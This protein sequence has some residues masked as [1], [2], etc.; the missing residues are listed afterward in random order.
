MRFNSFKIRLNNTLI[1]LFDIIFSLLGLIIFSP[2]FTIVSFSIVINSKGGIFYKQTRIGLNNQE[3]KLFKFRTMFINA[4][5]KGLLTVGSK[6]SRITKPGQM[7]RRYKLDELPQLLNVLM[8]DMSL[9]GPRPEVKKYVDL[10]NVSQKNVLSVKPGITDIASIE[11]INEN[12]ILAHSPNPEKT[13]IEEI[14]PAKIE[15]NM[16]Y[17]EH[18]N[19]VL[20]FKIITRTIF[21]IFF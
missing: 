19:I 9:V 14:M 15:L 1:R 10:Y 4:D 17:I 3:F 12:E 16:V 11:Y 2:I 13:Y 18:K 7:L 21:K 6:D 5:Q 20:Y 8:G